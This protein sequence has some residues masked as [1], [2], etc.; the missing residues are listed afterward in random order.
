MERVW[1]ANHDHLGSNGREQ[2]TVIQKERTARH[3]G[4]LCPWDRIDISHSDDLCARKFGQRLKVIASNT[5]T[6][7]NERITEAGSTIAGCVIRFHEREPFYLQSCFPHNTSRTIDRITSE[8]GGI[9]K[10]RSIL[11]CRVLGGGVWY[12][13]Y[14]TFSLP[15]HMP[16]VP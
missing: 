15:I 6:R 4:S 9:S 3:C 13:L 14:S 12:R 10:T 1:R 5:G 16:L 7:A 8:R 2:F 11:P